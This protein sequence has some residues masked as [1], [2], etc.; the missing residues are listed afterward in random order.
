MQK[1]A[2]PERTVLEFT[3]LAIQPDHSSTETCLDAPLSTSRA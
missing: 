1:A 2:E 3:T